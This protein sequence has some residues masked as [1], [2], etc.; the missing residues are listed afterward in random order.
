[1]EGYDYV[2]N[3]DGIPEADVGGRGNMGIT[4]R[5]IKMLFD[6]IKKRGD[7]NPDEQYSVSCSFL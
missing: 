7:Q 6:Q 2:I 5:A 3:E 4:P 1:M